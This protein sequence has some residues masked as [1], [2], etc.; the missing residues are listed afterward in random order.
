MN[1]F[2][3][4]SLLTVF[5]VSPHAD[6]AE[7]GAGS[8]LAGLADGGHDVTIALMTGAD[9][10]RRGEAKAAAA[11][12]GAGLVVDP[13]GRD[14]VLDVTSA[15][16]RWLEEQLAGADLVLAP[17]PDDTHQDHRATAAIVNSALRRTPISL[18]WYR[19]PS[20]GQSFAPT[21]FSAVTEKGTDRRRRAL[22]EHRTQA[23]RG[24]LDP[25]H[26]A[27]KDAWF[28]WLCGQAAAEPFQVVRHMFA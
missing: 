15:R 5:A 19:T 6:D 3:S 17:H 10:R 16:V 4:T 13:S 20:T 22:E 26:L 21:A 9:E 1:L 24:Y 27:L 28:G 18:A 12:L 11:T 7:Y 23:A 25:R 14:G 8:L 2:H